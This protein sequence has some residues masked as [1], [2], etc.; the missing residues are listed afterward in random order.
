MQVDHGSQRASVGTKHG[1]HVLGLIIGFLLI[2]EIYLVIIV[3]KIPNEAVWYP[4]AALTELLAVSLYI[5]PGLV[6][7]KRAMVAGS[8]NDQYDKA[9]DSTPMV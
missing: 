5:V 2:R 7:D 9:P 4:L 1:M 6:P 8:T 3:G